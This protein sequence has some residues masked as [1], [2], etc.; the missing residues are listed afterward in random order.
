[1]QR[2]GHSSIAVRAYKRIGEELKP[3]ASDVL[4]TVS[5]VTKKGDETVSTIKKEDKEI[6]ASGMRNR[7]VSFA[8]ASN[9][10]L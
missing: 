3:L 2:T 5:A 1:M 4:D 9:F 6:G 10:T 8:G 7:C